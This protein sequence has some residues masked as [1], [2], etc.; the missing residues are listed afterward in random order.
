MEILGPPTLG[1]S[2]DSPAFALGVDTSAIITKLASPKEARAL[3]C[4]SLIGD[5]HGG[6][7]FTDAVAAALEARSYGGWQEVQTPSG[8]TWTVILLNR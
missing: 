2:G 4:G 7:T 3:P 1:Q 8:E 5:M 6:L